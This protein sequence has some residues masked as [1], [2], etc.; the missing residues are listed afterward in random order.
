MV[1]KFFLTPSPHIKTKETVGL[2]M[3]DVIIAM[4]PILIASIYF[5]KTKALGIILI[6]VVGAIIFEVISQKIMGRKVWIKDGS[7]IVTGLLFAF[8]LPPTLPWWAVVVGIGV[9]IVL[10]KMVFGGMG[11]NIFNPAL[12]GRSFI[13]ASWGALMVGSDCWINIDGVA[14]ATVL[15]KIKSGTP[16]DVL[17]NEFGSKS[18]MYLDLFLG[19]IG[20]TIGET[21]ALAILIGGIYLL[22]RKQITWHI[23]ITFIGTVFIL[24]GLFGQDPIFHILTGGLM[25]G[26]F[27]M[28]TDMVTTPYTAKG[29]F[30]FG[31]GAGI[32]VTWIR[33]K[34]G[35]PEGVC[36]AI[37]IMN[38]VTPIINKYTK[39]KVFG[40]AIKNDKNNKI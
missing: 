40:G 18:G 37:L 36:Y 14:G 7:A 16:I 30:I 20:G 24:M 8:T 17:A 9:A 11:H 6:S 12:V 27:F 39:P 15:E 4:L 34:G 35:Y 31:I 38:G 21:S 33:L 19:K 32:L 10:G 22:I 28:A 26:A 2:I 3:L 13:L 1:K 29:K 5:F 25:L 23:P